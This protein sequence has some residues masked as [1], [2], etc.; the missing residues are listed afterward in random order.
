MS[1][2]IIIRTIHVCHAILQHELQARLRLKI[3][4]IIII[5]SKLELFWSV[6]MFL[7]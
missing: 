7:R 4:S 1:I 6:S 5:I 3:V 2:I